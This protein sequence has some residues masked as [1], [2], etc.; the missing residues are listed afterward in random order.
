MLTEFHH[1]H[2][3]SSATIDLAGTILPGVR[4]RRHYFD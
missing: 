4:E 3:A 1:Y 2:D